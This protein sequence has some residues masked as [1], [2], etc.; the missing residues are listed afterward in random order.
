MNEDD[1]YDN[2]DEI[3][4]DEKS[5]MP[6][7]HIMRTEQRLKDPLMTLGMTRSIC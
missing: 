3:Q 7:Q 6:S 5:M 1:K 2:I 4:D